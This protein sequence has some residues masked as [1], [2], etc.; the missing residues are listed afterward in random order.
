LIRTDNLKSE[1][2]AAPG[3]DLTTRVHTYNILIFL[4]ND[5]IQSKESTVAEWVGRLG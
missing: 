3:I 5:L 4:L 1:I 2:T